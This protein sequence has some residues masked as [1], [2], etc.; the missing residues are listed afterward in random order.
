MAADINRESFH[1]RASDNIDLGSPDPIPP[2]SILPGIPI[3]QSM[4]RSMRKGNDTKMVSY[5]EDIDNLFAPE[6]EDALPLRPTDLNQPY[7]IIPRRTTGLSE[8]VFSYVVCPLIQFNIFALFYAFTRPGGVRA[9]IFNLL[10]A[11]AG[12]AVI[13]MPEAFRSSGLVFSFF[14]LILACLVNYVSS[15]CLLYTSYEWGCF[16]YSKLAVN[17]HGKIFTK[18]VDFIF[19]INVFGTTLSY[20]VLIQ[21]NIVTSFKFIRK[22]GWETMPEIFT[23]EDSIFWVV[24]FAVRYND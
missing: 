20:A 16:S 21:G 1:S 14:Q 19:F 6:D 4:H 15:S 2:K 17:C 5:I 23:D 11:T 3:R 7:S 9:T 24:T 18:F 8:G 22:K 12:A 13:A 10:N